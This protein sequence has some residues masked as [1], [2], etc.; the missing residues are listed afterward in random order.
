MLISTSTIADKTQADF[1]VIW[2]LQGQGLILAFFK[3]KN[4]KKKERE[5]LIVVILYFLSKCPTEF[6]GDAAFGLIP[7]SHYGTVL[8]QETS[9]AFGGM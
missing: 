5:R 3:W 2:L 8:F 1:N 9:S 7:L 6:S 4:L